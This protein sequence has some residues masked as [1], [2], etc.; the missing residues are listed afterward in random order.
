MFTDVSEVRAIALMMEAA[1]TSKTSVNF[2]YTIR[3]NNPEV[4][5]LHTRRRE[6]LKAHLLKECW[7][8]KSVP[9][10]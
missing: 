9:G 3:C 2:C 8:Q 5:H 4:S 7:S 1:I 6:N 10:K